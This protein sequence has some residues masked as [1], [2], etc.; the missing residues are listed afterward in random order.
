MDRDSENFRELTL[1]FIST[2][3]WSEAYQLHRQSYG[4]SPADAKSAIHDLAQ[5]YGYPVQVSRSPAMTLLL[6]SAAVMMFVLLYRLM[7][8]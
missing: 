6:G 3:Q 1:Y 8:A 7:F 5:R 2:R 4:S